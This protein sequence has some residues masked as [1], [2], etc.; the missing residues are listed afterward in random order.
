MNYSY[1]E[2]KQILNNCNSMKEIYK[3][4][5]TLESCLNDYQCVDANRSDLQTSICRRINGL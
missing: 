5:E 3:V 2:I 1:N 4:S